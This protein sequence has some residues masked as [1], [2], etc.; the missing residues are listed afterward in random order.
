MSTWTI[1]GLCEFRLHLDTS[2]YSVMYGAASGTAEAAVR[3]ML[4]AHVEAGRLQIG[5]SY[6]VIVELLPQPRFEY[7][8]H[9]RAR[10]HF[11]RDLCGTNALAYGG[12]PGKGCRFSEDGGW[13]PQDILDEFDIERLVTEVMKLPARY[14]RQSGARGGWSSKRAFEKEVRRRPLMLD[15]LEADT[16]PLVVVLSFIEAGD[17]RRYILGEMTREDANRRL[18]A[19]V[20]DPVSFYTSWIEPHGMGAFDTRKQTL[21]EKL[22]MMLEQL[23]MMLSEGEELAAQVKAALSAKDGDALRAEGRQSLQK[24]QRELKDFK[25]EITSA[26]DL[27]ERVPRWKELYGDRSAKVAAEIM[28]AFHREKRRLKASDGIDFAHAM[29][30]PHVDLWRGDRAFGGLLI[31]HK[32]TGCERVVTSLQALPERIDQALALQAA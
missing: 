11:I 19:R 5:L 13:L 8:G 3:D 12:A 22:S 24:L 32:V 25:R 10:A 1:N 2:D 14:F 6:H 4:L 23:Q 17:L 21:L 29:F 27:C 30:L 18:Q 16:W 15:L 9:R 28:F 20:L 26:D 7:R 31:K